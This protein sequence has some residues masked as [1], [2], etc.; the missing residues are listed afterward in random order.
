MEDC[1]VMN[2]LVKEKHLLESV[3]IGT[4]ISN[5]SELQSSCNSPIE[6]LDFSSLKPSKEMIKI[7]GSVLSFPDMTTCYNGMRIMAKIKNNKRNKE[8]LFS[9]NAVTL[10]D[11]LNSKLKTFQIDALKCLVKFEPKGEGWTSADWIEK[12]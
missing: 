1:V 12:K 9:C 4:Q 2:Q 5:N 11:F 7:A 6:K 10:K 3:L 8:A